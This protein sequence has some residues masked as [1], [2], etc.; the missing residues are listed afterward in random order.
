MPIP[1]MKTIRWCA[2]DE[3]D[4]NCQVYSPFFAGIFQGLYLPNCQFTLNSMSDSTSGPQNR[5]PV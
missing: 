1:T 5:T 4:K 2:L 3:S